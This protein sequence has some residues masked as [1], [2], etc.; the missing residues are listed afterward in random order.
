MIL[1]APLFL[2][3]EETG[4]AGRTAVRASPV[5]LAEERAGRRQNSA[6]NPSKIFLPT[7]PPA[8]PGIVCLIIWMFSLSISRWFLA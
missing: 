3:Q 4:L 6:Y 8:V 1:S 5:F 7:D 2:E